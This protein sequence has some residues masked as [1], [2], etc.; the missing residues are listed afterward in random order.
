MNVVTKFHDGGLNMTSSNPMPISSS[1]L[2]TIWMAYQEKTMKLR[3]L[4]YFLEKAEDP[5]ASRIFQSEYNKEIQNIQILKEIFQKEGA[6]IPTG[7]T[8]KDVNKG[9][10]RL[11]DEIFDL[12]YIRMMAKVEIGLYALYSSMSYRKD[13]RSLNNRFNVEALETYN[14]S[15]QLLLD[16]GVLA[17]PPYVSMPKEVEFVHDKNYMSGFN[18]FSETRALN[19]VEIANIYQAIETNITGKQ[20]LIGFAQAA[21]HEQVRN[22]FVKGKE[23]A[24]KIITTLSDVLAKSDIQPPATWAGKATDSTI[25]PFSDKLLMYNTSLLSTFGLT[26]NA[27]GAAFS[28]RSDLPAKMALLAKGIYSYSKDGGTLMV[29]N[30]WMEEPPQAEDRYQLTNR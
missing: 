10:P 7:Y 25:A 21:S 19:T 22:Y 26:S 29:K 18:L 12:M 9:V 23:L 24:E 2:G 6:V 28:L 27:I 8:E 4:E 3:T 17:C 1:E 15:T 20:M 16:K 13:I 5:E 14:Q 30:G 11:F